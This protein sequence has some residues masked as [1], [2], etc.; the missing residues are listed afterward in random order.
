MNK[1][2]LLALASTSFVL[3]GS[4]AAF[5]QEEDKGPEFTPLEAFTCN[6]NDGKGS[7]DLDAAVE[8]WSAYM[9]ENGADKYLAMTVTPQMH[10]PDAFDVGW[11]GVAP[12]GELMGQGRD[13]FRANG[14]E[15]AAAFADV[16]DCDSHSQFATMQVKEPPERETPRSLVLSFS[17]CNVEE[18]REFSEVFAGM[19]AWA[20]Y[21]AENGYN[22]G[23]WVLFPAYGSGD[24]DF[25][26]KVV[27]AYDNHAG[28][29][30]DFDLY[31]TGGGY[32]KRREI[33]GSMLD[34]DVSRVYDATVHR[35]ISEDD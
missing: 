20:A 34:C 4:P 18:G 26:F 1:T 17:D 16:L 15:S 28:M 27:N 35:V 11:L 29:G 6:Y 32:V 14:G 13:G 21:Q 30:R 31:G 22:A 23:T 3:V 2:L 19:D 7:A 24:E 5:A 33:M 10:G 9:D 25:D 12:T 8:K